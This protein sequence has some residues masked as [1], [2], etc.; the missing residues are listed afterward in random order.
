[1]ETG[2]P[3]GTD[4]NPPPGWYPDPNGQLR[5]WD[6]QQWGEVQGQV[7]QTQAA[8]TTSSTD[9]KTMAMLAQLLGLLTGFIGPLIIYVINGDKDP[10]VKH[11]AA[12]A[13]NFHLTVLIAYVVSFV[14]MLVLIGFLTFFVVWIAAVVLSIMPTIAA[15]RG[16]W[17][18]YP[19]SIRMV[20]GAVG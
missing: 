10:F 15:N 12:E 17:Y 7:P 4:G 16:E 20:S 2:T 5:W 9:P 18:R 14:L 13:L 19:I 6:G 1:M 11:H 3:S 8:A